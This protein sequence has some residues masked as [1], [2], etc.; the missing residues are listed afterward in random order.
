MQ[1]RMPAAMCLVTYSTRSV[2]SGLLIVV[3]PAAMKAFSR[4]GPPATG[5]GAGIPEVE[6]AIFSRMSRQLAKVRPFPLALSF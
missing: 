1:Y 5:I 4:F 2:A 3:M 6:A